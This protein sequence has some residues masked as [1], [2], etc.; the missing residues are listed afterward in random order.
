MPN[1]QTGLWY[2]FS[3]P[4]GLQRTIALSL[5]QGNVFLSF[6]TAM[7]TVAGA[8]LW[9]VLALLLHSFVIQQRHGKADIF[10]IQQR[11]IPGLVPRTAIIVVPALL[12]WSGMMIA[13]IFT[14]K[15]A[16]TS[17]AGAVALGQADVCGFISDPW[18]SQTEDQKQSNYAR[19]MNDTIAARNYA[20]TFYFNSTVSQSDSPYITE[21][22]PHDNGTLVSCPF[23]NARRADTFTLD[24]G[25]YIYNLGPVENKN[26]TYRYYK[27]SRRD[28]VGYFVRFVIEILGHHRPPLLHDDADLNL[29]A[30]HL[31]SSFNTEWKPL[32]DFQIEDSDMSITILSSN[33]M[34]YT[35]AIRDPFFWAYDTVVEDDK[36][37]YTTDFMSAFMIC[38]DQWQFCN[39]NT[40]PRKCSPW[41]NY[42]P[43]RSS[44]GQQNADMDFNDAQIATALRV[45]IHM[46][47]TT[48][49]L[50]K[51]L[52]SAA[53]QASSQVI[54]N[55]QS[56]T[57]PNDQWITEVKGWFQIRLATIQSRVAAFIDVPKERTD[58]SVLDT[59]TPT[60]LAQKYSLTSSQ[61]DAFQSQ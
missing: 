12:L 51:V 47:G 50:V 13:F 56:I 18:A 41:S 10:D 33:N 11:K 16:T 35:D 9:G 8:S 36:T 28:H 24:D 2:D 52:N 7:V 25:V 30:F 39:P 22:L 20:Q 44:A 3:Q 32:E 21:I 23:Q 58:L 34:R 61:I 1:F 27:D 59:E 54:F 57:I 29:F 55:A 37:W 26:Y 31:N 49:G 19:L 4:V 45:A 14:S 53:F 40:N 15:V 46:E 60:W 43:F 38:A 6:L 42:G 17:G 5:A 48:G